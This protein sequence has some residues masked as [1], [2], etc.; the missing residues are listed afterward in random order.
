MTVMKNII[1]IQHENFM[2]K[3]FFVLATYSAT[4][5]TA[6]WYQ[7]PH[8]KMIPPLVLK[9]QSWLPVNLLCDC[10]LTIGVW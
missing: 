7:S 6:S 4:T 3:I 8:P 10:C 9:W 1:E 2:S 5:T